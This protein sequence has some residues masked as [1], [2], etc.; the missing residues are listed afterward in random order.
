MRTSGI[1]RRLEKLTVTFRPSGIRSFTLEELCRHWWQIDK[2]GF[3]TYMKKEYNG[4]RVF[5]DMFEREDAER[6][7]RARRCAR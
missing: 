4:L 5:A 2:R 1:G 3:L 6:K 7:A